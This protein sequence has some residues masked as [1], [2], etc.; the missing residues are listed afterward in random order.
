MEAHQAFPELAVVGHG[1]VQQFMN[2]HIIP[3]LFVHVEQF[4]VE[5]KMALRGAGDPLVLH[6]ANTEPCH[7]NVKFGGPI[8]NALYLSDTVATDLILNQL[9]G[10]PLEI[11][12]DLDA[13]RIGLADDIVEDRKSVV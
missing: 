12:I 10:F 11:A 1:E 3:D 13:L 9:V 8:A 2:N 7:L 4:G 6:G 5:I